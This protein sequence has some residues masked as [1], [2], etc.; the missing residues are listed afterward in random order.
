MAKK[1]AKRGSASL[2]TAPAAYKEN[3]SMNKP[4]GN[5]VTGAGPAARLALSGISR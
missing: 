2:A 1:W 5:A 4:A 3:R